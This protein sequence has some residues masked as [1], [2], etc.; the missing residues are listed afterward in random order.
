MGKNVIIIVTLVG[1]LIS[2]SFLLILLLGLMLPSVDKI[3]VSPDRDRYIEVIGCKL[4]Y[5]TT[6]LDKPPIVML[7]GFGGNLSDWEIIAEKVKCAK[8][9]SL[10]LVGFGLSEKPPMDY[11]IETQRN[12]LLAFLDA[13]NIE[14]AVL[15]GSSMGASIALWTAAKSPE[16]VAGLVVFAPSAYPDSM[17]HAWPGD[18]FYK[19]GFPNRILRAIVGMQ[20]FRTLFPKSLGLQAIDITAS[21]NHEFVNLLSAIQQPV[22]LIWSHGD[23]R[24]PFTYSEQYKKLLRNVEFIEAPKKLG[25]RAA[26]NPTPEI[27]DG[28]CTLV[29]KARFDTAQ[30]H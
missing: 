11:S 19:P 12:Y 20:I 27:Q 1:I 9:V 29:A 8:T 30:Q 6:D 18:I 7:H 22:L 15:V 2:F 3:T 14:K 24:V 28:I 17:R 23:K 16:R 13:M 4:R 25:H 10:D 21:Y 5:R 26:S